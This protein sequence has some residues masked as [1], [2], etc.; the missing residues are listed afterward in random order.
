MTWAVFL[1]RDGTINEE[2]GYLHDPQQLRLIPG[3]AEAIRRLNQAGVRVILVTNQAGIGRGYYE[4]EAMTATHEALAEK[5]AAHGAH[6]DAVYYCPHHPDV[7]CE[8]RKPQPGMLL[9]A[10][11]EQGIDLRRSFAVGD[12]VGDLEAGRRAGCRTVL[13]LSGYGLQ[14]RATLDESEHQPDHVSDDLAEA[15]QWIL[16]QEQPEP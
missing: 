16:Q 14:T 11:Q 10:A 13:V 3:A 8:C 7:D 12:K 4:L 5:L 2:V 9:Q 1:D 6:L 15:V